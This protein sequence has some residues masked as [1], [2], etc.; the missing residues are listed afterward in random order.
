MNEAQAIIKTSGEVSRHM[1]VGHHRRYYEVIQ[2][3]RELLRDGTLGQ[4]V[5]V[6]GQWTTRKADV[7]FE[8]EWRQLRSSGPVLINLIHEIDMLRYCCG[9]IRTLSAIFQSGLRGHP[10]E[11]SAAVI[12][13]YESGVL[14]RVYN[15]HFKTEKRP[16]LSHSGRRPGIQKQNTH[17]IPVFTGMTTV[18]SV[19]FVQ[20]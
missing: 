1:L 8:P 13:E 20:M 3:T 18:V 7:Y 11:E 4:L 16:V 14:G 6:T 2:R 17:W 9:E 12:M 5:G 15:Q 10:K 19:L